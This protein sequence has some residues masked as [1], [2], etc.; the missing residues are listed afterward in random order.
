MATQ[1]GFMEQRAARLAAS[2]TTP[3][4]SLTPDQT[5]EGFDDAP[6]LS[7]SSSRHAHAHGPAAAVVGAGN[8]LLS[9]V[10][11]DLYTKGKAGEGLK[12]A[13]SAG[14]P[15]DFG[16]VSNCRGEFDCLS[17]FPPVLSLLLLRCI[18][19]VLT[20]PAR[21]ADFWTRGRELGVTYAELYDVP[22]G[23]LVVT[24]QPISAIVCQLGSAG[25]A[26]DDA[27][28]GGA[29]A[30]SAHAR[31]W[32]MWRNFAGNAGS[33]YERVERGSAELQRGQA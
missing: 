13:S 27:A 28:E 4:A 32:S 33:G 9:I 22:P 8:W 11:L 31:R 1:T 6:T 30:G 10:G 12:K 14:N 25:A 7:S 5:A 24:H 26:A 15:F 3:G 20:R 23:G 21:M 19:R 2:S 16:V 17:F 29:E 18:A